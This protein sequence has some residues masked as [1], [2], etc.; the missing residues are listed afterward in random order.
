MT[1]K[2]TTQG[3][4]LR[5]RANAQN[6]SFRISLLWSIHIINSVKKT[7]LSCY[8]PHRRSTTVSLEIYP[9]KTEG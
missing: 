7:K 6:V 1:S 5:Q 8:T 2:Q 3:S 9:S 4:L